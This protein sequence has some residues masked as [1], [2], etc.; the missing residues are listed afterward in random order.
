M[1]TNLKPICIL[2]CLHETSQ[3]HHCKRKRSNWHFKQHQTL[4]AVE[5]NIKVTFACTYQTKSFVLIYHIKTKSRRNLKFLFI[6]N[7]K[8]KRKRLRQRVVFGLIGS[9]NNCKKKKNWLSCL[10]LWVET[11]WSKHKA[12]SYYSSINGIRSSI[13]LLD[14]LLLLWFLRHKIFLHQTIQCIPSA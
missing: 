14:H 13:T 5:T 4:I 2:L 1:A 8:Y 6:V 7:E 3:L 12:S 10:H 11:C 9:N